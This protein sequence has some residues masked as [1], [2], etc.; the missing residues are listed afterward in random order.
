MD[1]TDDELELLRELVRTHQAYLRVITPFA[2]Q[3]TSRRRYRRQAEIA[4]SLLGKIDAERERNER[5]YANG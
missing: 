5:V 1:F 2:M 3:T 4:G